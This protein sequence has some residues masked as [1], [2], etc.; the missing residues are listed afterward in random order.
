M[1]DDP[2]PVNG[3]NRGQCGSRLRYMD[4]GKTDQSVATIERYHF[5]PVFRC[6]PV[7]EKR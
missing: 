1:Q 3:M 2:N 6:T 5:E 7:T 4:M